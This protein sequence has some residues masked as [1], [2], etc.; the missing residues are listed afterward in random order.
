MRTKIKNWKRIGI[1]LMAV[2]GMLISSVQSVNA[3]EPDLY[4]VDET[5]DNVFIEEYTHLTRNAVI[6]TC[7]ASLAI[8]SGKATCNGTGSAYASMA[9]STKITMYL[10]KYGSSWSNVTSWSTTSTSTAILSKTQSVSSGTYRVKVVCTAGG[11]TVTVYSTTK[12]Y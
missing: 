1:V 6:R 9:S 12:T 2:V 5:E 7:S 3:A 4:E 10:Q 11:E 8:S